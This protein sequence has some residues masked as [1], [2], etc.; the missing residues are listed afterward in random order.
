MLR[1]LT[2][3]QHALPLGEL[4]S[5]A[6]LVSTATRIYVYGIGR[7]GLILNAFAMRLAQMGYRSSV[8]GAV[9]TTAIRKDD[10]LVV[11]TGSG[12]TESVLRTVSRAVGCGA[13]VVMFTTLV[14]PAPVGVRLLTLPGT[15]KNSSTPGSVQPLGSLFEQSLFLYLEEFVLHLMAADGIDSSVLAANHANLE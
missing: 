10:L 15:S 3:H 14:E 2:A 6:D 9:T 5:I 4:S 13:A 7:T 11:A 12:E 8:V 1:E